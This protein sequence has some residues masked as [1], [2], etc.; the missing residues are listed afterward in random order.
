M[1]TETENE[2]FTI[3]F[4]INN[5]CNLRCVHCYQNDR[6]SGLLDNHEPTWL[7]NQIEELISSFEQKPRVNLVVSGGEPLLHN[8][9]YELLLYSFFLRNYQT[10]LLT[11]ATLIDETV[12]QKLFLTGFPIVRVSLDSIVPK[13]YEYIRGPGT[14]K[15]A[16]RGIKFL[17]IVGKS[18]QI[19]VTLLKGINDNHFSDLFWFCSK[20]NIKIINMNRFFPQGQYK[21][22]LEFLY[23][24]EEFKAVLTKI[25]ETAAE[26]P[27]LIIVIKD[28]LV[29][30]LFKDLPKNIYTDVCCYIGEKFMAI[31]ADGSVYACRKLDI[32][33]GDMKEK[34]LKEIWYKSKNLKQLIN[35]KKYLK[36]KCT[37]C[38]KLSV[39]KGGC[40]AASFNISKTK[41]EPDPCC[42]L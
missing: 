41:F 19:S 20:Y 18:V 16:L 4:E 7:L 28:P 25:I 23:T 33:I 31:S 40:T 36:G 10:C 22:S 2:I 11:N 24:K 15:L 39:C 37:D 35:R 5:N 32:K 27:E 13:I 6:T 26:F 14:F 21:N 38:S 9:V 8:K 29:K 42:W 12:A 30:V 17:Q 1:V 3:Q 34:T